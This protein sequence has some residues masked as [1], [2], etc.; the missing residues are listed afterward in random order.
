EKLVEYYKDIHDLA[1]ASYE[2]LIE[3]PEIGE[4]IAESL[5]LYFDDKN[6]NELIKRLIGF[7]LK[8]KVDETKEKKGNNVLEGK[9]FVISGVFEKVSR[10]G[11]KE[12]IKN[13]GGKVLSSISSKLDFLVAGDKMGP[14]K[15]EKAQKLNIQ[16]ISEDDFLNMIGKND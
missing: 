3:V 1:N 12:L 9:T 11:L 10:D 16:T 4:R 2:E 13:Q 15:M 6:N 14:S 5:R 8:T 7:G